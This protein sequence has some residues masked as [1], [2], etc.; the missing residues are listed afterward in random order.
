MHY[1]TDEKPFELFCIENDF[2]KYLARCRNLFILI[3][4]FAHYN[5]S[6]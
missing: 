6:K 4:C 2:A 5:S 3:F 1:Y